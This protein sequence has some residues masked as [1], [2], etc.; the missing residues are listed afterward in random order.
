MPNTTSPGTNSKFDSRVSDMGFIIQ[1]GSTNVDCKKKTPSAVKR[2][3]GRRTQRLERQL[4]EVAARGVILGGLAEK[5]EEFGWLDAAGDT[6]VG[7][8]RNRV[9]HQPAAMQFNQTGVF[10]FVIVILLCIIMSMKTLI[11]VVF[12]LLVIALVGVG[13]TYVVYGDSILFDPLYSPQEQMQRK[14]VRVAKNFPSH[15]SNYKLHSRGPQPVQIQTEC[16]TINGTDTCQEVITAVYHQI[17]GSKA[18]FVNLATFKSG[19]A[20]VEEY[21]RA[22]GRSEKLASYPYEVLRVEQHELGWFPKSGYDFI[23][24]QEGEYRLHADG[25]ES[26]SYKN[27]ATGNNAVI[28]HFIQKYPPSLK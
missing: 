2:R 3:V 25:S 16:N 18:V 15:I 23:L 24:T 7:R 9:L 21:L 17:D 8:T 11:W 10:A 26:G 19:R 28:I 12:G 20:A 4:L 14:L 13:G 5:I 6:N 27:P 1:Y 22:Q